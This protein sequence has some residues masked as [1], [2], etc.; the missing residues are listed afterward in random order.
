MTKRILLA[1]ALLVASCGPN[2]DGPVPHIVV[3]GPTTTVRANVLPDI[4]RSP[5]TTLPPR[6]SRSA[7]RSRSAPLPA[8]PGPAATTDIWRALANCEA[9]GNPAAVSA[10]G[11]YYG[12]FQW[13][14]QTWRGQGETGTPT[15]YPYEYQLEVAKRL[16]AARG[17]SPWPTCARKL[18]LL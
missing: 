12:A 17:W 18:G 15:A 5:T 6:A 10:N 11:R 3:A 2:V 9:G 8:R 4:T 13:D 14:L 16:Q 1:L 7:A